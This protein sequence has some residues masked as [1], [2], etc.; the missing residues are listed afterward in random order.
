MNNIFPIETML[1]MMAKFPSWTPRNLADAFTRIKVKNNKS[2]G[3]IC[4]IEEYLVFLYFENF[5][6]LLGSE[7]CKKNPNDNLEHGDQWSDPALTPVLLSS[8]GFS[9]PGTEAPTLAVLVF[10]L[11]WPFPGNQ[12]MFQKYAPCAWAHLETV[13]APS[14][15]FLW[16]VATIGSIW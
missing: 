5:I 13:H 14:T 9:E 15:I 12:E 11:Y 4:R 6:G 7:S 10:R 8:D 3:F 16:L 1:E 2:V